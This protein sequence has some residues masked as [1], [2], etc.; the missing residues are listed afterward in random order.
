MPKLAWLPLALVACTSSTEI[1]SGNLMGSVEG[2]PWAF[3]TG[4]TDFYLSKNGD[5]FFAE[6]YAGAYTPCTGSPPTGAHLIVSVPKATG[7]YP[8]NLSRNMTFVTASSDNL[9]AT[10]GRIVVDAVTATSVEGGL[11]GIY[12]GHNEVDGHF[13]LTVCLQ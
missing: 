2:Q 4:H 11:H 7:D 3:Q 10:T 9:I 8:M 1:S 6:L 5:T 13:T 12:D